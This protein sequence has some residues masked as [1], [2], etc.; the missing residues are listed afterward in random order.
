MNKV[1]PPARAA[2]ILTLVYLLVFFGPAP[3]NGD[4]SGAEVAQVEDYGEKSASPSFPAGFWSNGKEK[5]AGK[6]FTLEAD[7]SFSASL[8]PGIG[9]RGTVTGK[10][11]AQGNTYKL[12]DMK[13]ITGKFWGRLVGKYNNTTLEVEFLDDRSFVLTCKENKIVETMFGGVFFRR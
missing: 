10:L 7:G 6:T 13:E 2:A 3:L 9:G 5:A 8:D 1:K 11:L 4:S 12:Q